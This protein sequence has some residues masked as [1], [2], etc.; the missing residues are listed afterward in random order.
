MPRRSILSA[1]ERD[2]LLAMP[3]SDEDLIRAYTFSEADLSMIR[4]HRGPE[5]R[6]GQRSHCATCAT[7]E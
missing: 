5:N 4:Q 7:Q 2:S 6:L 3:E 1:I